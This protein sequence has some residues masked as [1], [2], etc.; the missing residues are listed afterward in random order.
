MKCRY[1]ECEVL[2]LL[3]TV[4]FFLAEAQ[5]QFSG[6]NMQVLGNG[7]GIIASILSVFLF[8]NHVPVLGWVG[9]GI[10][11]A[12]VV[13]YSESKKVSSIASPSRRSGSGEWSS[14]LPKV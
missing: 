9:Y 4:S 6:D 2:L 13:A 10:T 7:K 3:V 12:G 8:G 1:I 5:H 14:L 11:I